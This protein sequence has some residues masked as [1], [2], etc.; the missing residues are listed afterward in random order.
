MNK[1]SGV[2]LH[3][4]NSV[5][6]VS[7]EADGVVYQ[8]RLPNDPAQ[9]KAASAVHCEDLLGILIDSNPFTVSVCTMYGRLPVVKQSYSHVSNIA[10]RLMLKK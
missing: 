10:D 9:I 6:V 8:R 1:F 5:I 2:D 4:N 7:D 3:S